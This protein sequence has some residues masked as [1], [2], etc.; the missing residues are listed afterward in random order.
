MKLAIFDFDG[1]LLKVDTLPFLLKLWKRMGY[2]RMRLWATYMRVGL[3][4]A[5]Y[6]LTADSKMDREQMKKKALQK[7]THIFAHM[8]RAQVDDFFAASAPHLFEQLNQDVL[9]EIKDA[10]KQGFHTVLLSGCYDGLLECVA[11]PLGIDTVMGTQMIYKD[12]MVDVC[13]RMVIRTGR[14]K[15]ARIREMY[16]DAD[17]NVSCAYADSISDVALLEMVGTPVAVVPDPGL[18]EVARARN[19]RVIEAAEEA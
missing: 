15:L 13:T 7:F 18:S 1:T 2:S 3:L 10:K 6:K 8:N 19:W 14:D 5:H 9:N 16:P 4:Y 11:K 12:G 17:L